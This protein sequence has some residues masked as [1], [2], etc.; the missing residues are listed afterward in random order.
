MRTLALVVG[1]VLTAATFLAL[2]LAMLVPRHS[3]PLIARVINS[4]TAGVADAPLR[5]LR[6]Y[7]AQDRWLSGAAPIALLLQL[8]TY[9]VLL[10]LTLGLVVYGTRD[11]DL[12]KSMF[13][14]GATLTTL[15]I[16]EPVTVASAITTFVAAFLGL[17][18]IA[19]FV[20]YLLA[21]Y[22]AHV[23]RESG[24]AR[25]ALLA[26]EPAWGPMMIARAELLGPCLPA[27]CLMRRC[28]STGSA[29]PG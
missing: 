27:E 19:I 10:I 13:Q 3:E 9:V 25:A 8:T 6:T 22:G 18:V 20:G 4:I 5:L 2:C 16:V 15:G 23:D 24:M 17:V 11:L 7:W 14:S 29:T 28:G 21:L 26:G 12:V 1:I